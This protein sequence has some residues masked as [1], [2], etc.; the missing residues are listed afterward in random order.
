MELHSAE[1]QALLEQ[2]TLQKP[3]AASESW[4]A[5]FVP[6]AAGRIPVV[7]RAAHTTA[8]DVLWDLGCGDG[9]ILHQAAA[10]Y[11][12]V[13][14][15]ID[16]D[17]ACIDK[18]RALADELGVS[19]LCTFVCADLM[20]L[21]PGAL[22]GNDEGIVDIGGTKCRAPSVMHLYMTM[23]ALRRLSG[24]LHTE[25]SAGDFSIVT[26]VEALDVLLDHE[27]DDGLFSEEV[28]EYD[29]PIHRAYDAH[30][31]F[32]VPPRHT[33][34]AAWAEAERAYEAGRHG[35]RET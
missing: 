35:A 2:H 20:E 12:C 26:S 24:W 21:A 14:V 22:R 32:V 5:P 11:H 28:A 33:S 17:A 29:W 27:A 7:L 1:Q 6:T 16:I 31:V 30:A 23:H 3:A 34:V 19:H 13:C 8:R 15:G 9:R 4:L 10:T 25:W 18:A